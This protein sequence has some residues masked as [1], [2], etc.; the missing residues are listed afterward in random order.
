M[1][2]IIRLIVVMVTLF[3]LTVS[4]VSAE[5]LTKLGREVLSSKDGWAAY[6][7]G[8]TGGS[9][10]DE[11]HVFTV[12][13]KSE[14]IKALDDASDIPKIIYVKGTIDIN[15]DENNNPMKA[16]DYADPAYDFDD[17]LEVY[18]PDV[19][20]YEKEV[21]GLL[22]EARARSQK[23]QENNIVLHVGSNTTIFGLGDDA[24]IVGGALVLDGVENVIIRNIEFE[25]PLDFFP[26]W[27]PTDGEYG[28]WNS[29]YDNVTITDNSHHIWIDHNTFSDGEN[30]DS[31]FGT[32]FDRLY[33]RHDGLLDI[34]NGSNYVTVSYNVFKDHDKVTIVGSSDSK[35]SDRGKLKVTF[36]HNYYKN[37]NQR[38]PRVR[39]G[40]VHVYNNYYEFSKDA[41]YEFG[42]V[43]GVGKESKIYVENNYF[44]FD[45][46]VELSK[47]IKDWKGTTIFETGSMVN[48]SSKH[49]K[50][51]L[52]AEFNKKNTVQ[53]NEN[54]DWTPK[55]YERIDPTQSV[56]AKVKAHAGAGNLH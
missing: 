42:Y 35:T 26:Q 27:D 13:K 33:Q 32:Y 55:L 4:S 21:D 12:T 2:K 15:V 30:V 51:D 48:G 52:I 31:D 19:W 41:N 44:N 39:F 50:V 43:W 53:L 38:L 28:E 47:I 14:L 25:A 54:V 20:G 17:Y 3:A 6:G 49:H 45:W 23:N 8:T 34:K 1:K 10:A 46:D 56:P 40:E 16:E 11:E 5:N 36:H 18:S 37:L 24:T 7:E 9:A 22:E 29:D